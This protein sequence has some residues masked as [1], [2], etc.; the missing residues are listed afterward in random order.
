MKI[1]TFFIFLVIFLP[2]CSKIE[3]VRLEY[4]SSPSEIFEGGKKFTDWSV[5]L[6][7]PIQG[8]SFGKN[9]SETVIVEVKKERIIFD[10]GD[11]DLHEIIKITGNE[12]FLFAGSSNDFPSKEIY[13]SENQFKT[14]LLDNGVLRDLLIDRASGVFVFS[15]SN[16]VKNKIYT[17]KANGKCKKA[18]T[19][20]VGSF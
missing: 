19:N 9:F 2:A 10:D 15:E 20:K 4:F 11:K 8:E 18:G 5:I 13:I 7:C 12:V 3:S 17:V 14:H 6:E 1:K 16:Y